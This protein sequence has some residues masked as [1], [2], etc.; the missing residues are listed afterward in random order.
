MFG[1]PVVVLGLDSLDLDLT[2]GGLLLGP[3]AVSPLII[4]LLQARPIFD[5]LSHFEKLLEFR[6][7]PINPNQKF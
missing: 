3:D 7:F 1:F 2:A 4:C 5:T 6:I